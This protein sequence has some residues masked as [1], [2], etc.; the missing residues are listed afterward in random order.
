MLY[1]KRGILIR[2]LKNS[3]PGLIEAR[4]HFSAACYVRNSLDLLTNADYET[5]VVG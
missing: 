5:L 3:L 4:M 2:V 1:T